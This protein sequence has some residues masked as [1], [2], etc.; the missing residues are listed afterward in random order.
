MVSLIIFAILILGF[1]IGLKR[2]FILQLF[3]LVSYIVSFIVAALYYD[4]LAHELELWIPYPELS[5]DTSWAIFMQTLPLESA[6]YNG[7]SFVIIFFVVKIILQIIAS[8]LDFIADL[9]II[10]HFNKCFGS[11]SCFLAVYLSM[12]IVLFI[13]ALTPL[14][15][16]LQWIEKSTLLKV[17]IEYTPVLSKHVEGMWFTKL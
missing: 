13:L 4:R 2:G 7:A 16:V 17:M 3:H 12:F 8:M 15:S 11:A 1:F 10:R 9:P 5:S 14:S 6:F